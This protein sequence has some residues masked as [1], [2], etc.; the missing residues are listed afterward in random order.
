MG[1][2]ISCRGRGWHIHFPTNLVTR[3]KLSPEILM[4]RNTSIKKSCQK[5]LGQTASKDG[6]VG[7]QA[8]VSFDAISLESGIR[9]ASFLSDYKREAKCLNP[10]EMQPIAGL[11]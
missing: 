3:G 9:K 7:K 8:W 6:S 5:D 1:T 2:S 10:F 11:K 4:D